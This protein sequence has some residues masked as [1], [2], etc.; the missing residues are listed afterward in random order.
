MRD[1]KHR[2]ADDILSRK[3][4]DKGAVLI[5]GP[6]WCGKTTTAEQVAASVLYMDD[7]EKKQQNTAMAELN[8]SRLPTGNAPRL[9]DEWQLAPKLWDAIRFQVDHRGLM[10]QFILTGSSVPADTSEITHS[11]TGRFTWLT[12]R[13]MSLYESGD[14]SGDVSLRSLFNSQTDVDGESHLDIER[15]AFLTCRG[16][17]PQSIKMRDETALDQAFDYYDAVVHS[18]INRADN[19]TKNPERVKRLMRSYAR[20]QGR[21]IPN[22]VIAQDIAA[23]D[24]NSIDEETVALYINALKKIFVI[25]DMPAW[26]PNLRSKT[27]IRSSDTRYY[28][29]PSIAAAALGIGPQ[30]LLNDL[31]TFGFLFETLC[32][33]GLRVFADALNGTV[34]H[35]R[36]KSGLEC[37][38]VIH[39]RNGSYGFIEIKLGGERLIEEGASNLTALCRKLDTDKMKSPSFLM[40]L[41][42]TGDYAYRRSDGIMIVPIGCLKD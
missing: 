33:R 40:V 21:Q 12:M 19:I 14:S 23:N 36:D 5:E 13:P 9:I 26:N 6:K 7:P 15:L 42:G 10:G 28:I 22:T 38:A 30:D 25:E 17:W 11:G 27:A 41:T 39:L 16:G 29:D 20:N 24:E 2:V 8:P 31:N 1:Y 18:D 32:I 3:L 34:Y 4:E 35:Y 37:D